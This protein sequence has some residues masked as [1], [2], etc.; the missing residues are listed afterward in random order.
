VSIDDVKEQE[1]GDKGAD[2][3]GIMAKID[4]Q[5]IVISYFADDPIAGKILLAMAEGA[6]GE[7]LKQASGLS[8]TEY[9]SKRKKI[10]RRIE[11]LKT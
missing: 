4:L 8:P 5:R 10:R 11:K 6:K 3:R 9:E 7:D 1:V 2:E